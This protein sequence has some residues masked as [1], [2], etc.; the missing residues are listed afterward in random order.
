MIESDVRTQTQAGRDHFRDQLQS[1]RY[2]A[3]ETRNFDVLYAYLTCNNYDLSLCA[4]PPPR[5]NHFARVPPRRSPD[6]ADD[7]QNALC[8]KRNIQGGA[9]RRDVRDRAE[10]GAR[11]GQARGDGEKARMA[12]Y[13]VSP[14]MLIVPPELLLYIATASEEGTVPTWT[15]RRARPFEAG[16]GL[17]G[18]RAPRVR[19]W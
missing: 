19:R 2:C 18:A 10:G 7:I 6:L 4:S 13:Q 12:R 14:N 9:R 15:A 16:G 3:Q 17:R 11:P 1:I 8:P 5:T